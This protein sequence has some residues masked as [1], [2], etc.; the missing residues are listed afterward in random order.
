MGMIR[1]SVIATNANRISLLRRSRAL[2]WCISIN[3]GGLNYLV[4][5]TIIGRGSSIDRCYASTPLLMKKDSVILRRA[6]IR[7]PKEEIENPKSHRIQQL[8]KRHQ[9][10][11]PR[12]FKKHHKEPYKKPATKSLQ[13]PFSAFISCLP[14]LEE[15]LLQE[16]HYLQNQWQQFITTEETSD[17]KARAV[18]GGV[19]VSVPKL[20]HLY[21]LH[22]YLGTASHIYLRLNGDDVEGINTNTPPLFR[23]RGFPELKR[24][25]KD[26]IIAQR[27]EDRLLL[28][29]PSSSSKS[30]D[31]GR[32]KE[33]NRALPWQLQVHV[34]TSKS[35]LMHTKAVEERVRET[36]GDVLGVDELKSKNVSSADNS[37]TRPVVRL[38]VRIERDVVQLSLDSSSSSSAIPLHMRGYRLVPHKA[39]LREDLSFALLVAGGLR[40][41]WNLNSLHSLLG[42]DD[43]GHAKTGTVDTDMNTAKDIASVQLFDPLCG[44]GTI[45]IEG[46]SILAG[47]PPGRLRPPPFQGTKFCNPK[48]WDAMK[49]KSNK[50]KDEDTGNANKILVSANDINR[51]AI[52]AA[53]SNAKRAG[54]EELI[55]FT[56]GSFKVHPLLNS[57]RQSKVKKLSHSQPLL[58]VTNPPYGK[59]LSPQSQAQH[60]NYKQIAKAILSSQNKIHCTMIGTDPRS[61]RESSLPLEVAF[62]TKQG[63][64][65]V[66]A[67]TGTNS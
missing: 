36:I 20:A 59:R 11:Q 61:L 33:S 7:K 35:K 43:D 40:P 21:V 44:S 12:E 51:K 25:L 10:P 31:D 22:L 60:S 57:S 55:N 46:A 66:V 24:K 2:P 26:L 16:V 13:G 63:G 19:E 23:A 67:M 47:L 64:L 48:L 45:A 39:P 3:S 5:N 27:W 1:F 14:G 15:L 17:R 32:R 9:S 42:R 37:D 18:P 56:V 50:S 54:V 38:V 53:R 58:L 28:G 52:D 41:S 49:S 29:I 62:S 34:T 8:K 4:N 30:G 6:G 65:N